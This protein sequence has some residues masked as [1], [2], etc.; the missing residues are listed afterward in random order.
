MYNFLK[1]TSIYYNKY[2]IC[3]NIMIHV[4]ILLIIMSKI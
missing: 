2:N 1:I 3:I 4:Y